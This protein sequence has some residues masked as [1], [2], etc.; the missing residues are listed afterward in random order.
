MPCRSLKVYFPKWLF[1]QWNI[2]PLLKNFM[3]HFPQVWAKEPGKGLWAVYDNLWLLITCKK[4]HKKQLSNHLNV[5]WNVHKK[6]MNIIGF[7]MSKSYF[8]SVIFIQFRHLL[9]SISKDLLMK[10]YQPKLLMGCFVT[11]FM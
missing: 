9:T 5:S 4:L 3:T 6:L 8:T 11:V 1:Y 2:F 7:N 10:F